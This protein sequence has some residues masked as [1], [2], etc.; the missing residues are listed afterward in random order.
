MKASRIVVA[1]WLMALLAACG[2]G[3][4]SGP[5]R[6]SLVEPPATITTMTA[7]DIDAATASSGL[8]ALSGKALCDVKVV[9]LNYHTIGPASES[10]NS[11][12]VML[13]PTGPGLDLLGVF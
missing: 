6:G 13:V 5:A 10:T 1:A 8:Q 4:D 11:S 7:A 2:G 9:A 12:G 3:G